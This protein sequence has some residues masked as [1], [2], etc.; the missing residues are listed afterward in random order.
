MT[1]F[2]IQ[3]KVADLSASLAWY[4]G[5]LG[6]RVLLEDRPNGFALLGAGAA[7][8]ALKQS[9]GKG[10]GRGAVGLTFEVEDLAAERARL[11]GLG[12]AIAE[13]AENREEGYRE[14]RLADPD[15]TPIRLFSWIEGGPRRDRRPARGPAQT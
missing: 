12:L 2:M 1:L 4:G 6:L 3:V 8:L 7:K 11:L 9:G 5:M 14:V 10:T 13:P 15:G